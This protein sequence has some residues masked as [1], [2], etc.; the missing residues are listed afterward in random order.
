MN[1]LVL[2]VG[3]SSLK[4][5]LYGLGEPIPGDPLE[6]LWDLQAD[7]ASR[8]GPAGIRIR[9]KL[10]ALLNRE[11]PIIRLREEFVP[12]IE[13]M[14]SGETRVIEDRNQI[15]AVGHR[16]VHGGEKLRESTL[17]TPEVAEEIDRLAI[18]APA[19][20]PI[21]W[22]VIEAMERIL[23]RS[24]PQVAVFDTAFHSTLPPEAYIYGGP[25]ECLVKGISRYGSH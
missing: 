8:D 16:V 20:N 12:S 18:F 3:S 21:E 4:G 11:V 14:W 1:I 24:V 25:H 17:I 9:T 10:G 7:W 5:H 22:S 13:T 19:H 15:E 2:N 23:G 6:P